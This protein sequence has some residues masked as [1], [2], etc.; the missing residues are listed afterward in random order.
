MYQF[1][2]Y[3]VN[4]VTSALIHYQNE[5]FIQMTIDFDKKLQNEKDEHMMAM[6]AILEKTKL[7]HAEEVMKLKESIHTLE[8]SL[9]ESESINE[10]NESNK[11][12]FRSL[13]ADLIKSLEKEKEQNIELRKIIDE[14]DIYLSK[15][16][17]NLLK[18][19]D[20]TLLYITNI[21][22]KT[23]YTKH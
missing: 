9:K 19:F 18:M 5:K 23:E 4:E 20:N 7:Q 14:G 17:S 22:T 15:K 8:E 21:D 16:F 1:G 12:T 2:T 3:P 13:I 6:T 10:S 11:V